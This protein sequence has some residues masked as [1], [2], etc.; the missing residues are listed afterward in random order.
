MKRTALALLLLIPQTAAAHVGEHA[1][2]FWSGLTHPLGGVD[3]V[4]AMVAVG[5]W[6]ALNGG[7]AMWAM[8]A[9]FVAAMLAGGAAGFAGLAVPGIEPAILASIL[10]IGLAVAFAVR[11]PLGLA[12]AALAVFGAAH[13]VA[14][15]AEGPASGMAVYAAGFAL[16]TLGLHGLGLMLG[17][18]VQRL[19]IR[20]LGGLTAAAGTVLAVA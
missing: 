20:V 16:A 17:R 13:G 9:A 10:C 7:R 14:H 11:L 4:L 5:L 6:A 18:A 8:P 3:H 15:G 1:G 2:G 12:V 19:P